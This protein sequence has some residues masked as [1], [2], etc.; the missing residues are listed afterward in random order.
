MLGQE[1]NSEMFV[2]V[3]PYIAELTSSYHSEGGLVVVTDGGVDRVLELIGEVNEK[4][5]I[6]GR[7]FEHKLL[8]AP[9]PEELSSAVVYELAG[10]VAERVLVIPNDDC[11]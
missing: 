7:Y 10:E 1:W 5:S 2:Y 6:L 9:T 4:V 11:Y 3:L 8:I